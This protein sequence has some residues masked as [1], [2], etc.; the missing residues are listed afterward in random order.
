M[1]NELHVDPNEAPD[2]LRI[3]SPA[4]NPASLE[5]KSGYSAALHAFDLCLR[6]R[7]GEHTA[8]MICAGDYR[9]RLTDDRVFENPWDWEEPYA[10]ESQQF[11]QELQR[12]EWERAHSEYLDG[13]PQPEKLVEF[14]RMLEAAG[15]HLNPGWDGS[16]H[17][18]L[19]VLWEENEDEDEVAQAFIHL[20]HSCGEPML[21]FSPGER[22]GDGSEQWDEDET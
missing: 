12:E 21:I 17:E 6:D 2:G 19:D 4:R 14:A 18:T 20:Y 7:E 8:L 11:W 9:L 15:W 16:D 10:D 13:L 22:A 1:I 3:W 5:S